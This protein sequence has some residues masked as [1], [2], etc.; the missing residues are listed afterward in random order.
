MNRAEFP[1]QNCTEFWFLSSLVGVQTSQK[2]IKE[3]TQEPSLSI[4]PCTVYIL[5]EG[6]KLEGH[7]S[8]S[9][10]RPVHNSEVPG[11]AARGPSAA[12]RPAAAPTA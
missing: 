12:T 10:Q 3:F 11:H 8:N 7:Q 5:N 4:Y 1:G 2:R 6:L 9:L